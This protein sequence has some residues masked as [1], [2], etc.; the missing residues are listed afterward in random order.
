MID[1]PPAQLATVKS[2][3]AKHAPGLK[4]VAFGSRVRGTPK[5][6][7]DLD[8][9]IMSDVPLSLEALSSLR[10]AFSES[11]LPI[12]VDIVDWSTTEDAFRRIIEGQAVGV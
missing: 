1:L 8:L 9:C 3:L 11:D 7:S 6:Y 2:I 10:A 5:P 4:V 12:R